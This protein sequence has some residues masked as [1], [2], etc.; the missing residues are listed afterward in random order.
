M[1]LSSRATWKPANDWVT[2]MISSRLTLRCGGSD[3]SQRMVLAISS[4][5]IGWAPRYILSEAA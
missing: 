4:A 2:G 1:G 5:V 3:A